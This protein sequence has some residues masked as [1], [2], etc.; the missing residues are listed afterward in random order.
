[1]AD[2]SD[3]S[4]FGGFF[5]GM[6][7]V[8]GILVAVSGAEEGEFLAAAFGGAIVG[9]IVGSIVEA[10]LGV[11]W[12]LLLVALFVLMVIVRFQACS[13]IREGVQESLQEEAKPVVEYQVEPTEERVQPERVVA[14]CLQNNTNLEKIYYSYRW[15]QDAWESGEVAYQRWHWFTYSSGLPDKFEVRFDFDLSN[16]DRYDQQRLTTRQVSL[17]M[18]C[19]DTLIYTFNEVG[20]EVRLSRPWF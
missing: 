20:A 6:G 19:S 5:I 8:A 1:M 11:V 2:Q 7:V 14:V 15:G 17:P 13:A 4:P 18:E 12:K 9:L 16:E 3:D 10:V